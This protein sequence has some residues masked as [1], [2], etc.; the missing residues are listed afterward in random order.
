[1]LFRGGG[2]AG[3]TPLLELL[4]IYGLLLYITSEEPTTS[5]R[6]PAWILGYTGCDTGRGD[7]PIAAWIICQ[8]EHT[9]SVELVHIH[10]TF[11]YGCY[12]GARYNKPHNTRPQTKHRNPSFSEKESHL[13]RLYFMKGS[14]IAHRVRWPWQSQDYFNT[15]SGNSPEGARSAGPNIKTHFNTWH[16][17]T[18]VLRR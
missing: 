10:T 9:Y 18:Y 3:V 13:P 15:K 16:I 14:V 6:L 2:G 5:S 17:S 11:T 8:K 12:G 1:M 7:Q 4:W